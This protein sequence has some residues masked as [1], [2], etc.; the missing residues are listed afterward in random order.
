MTPCESKAVSL[1]PPTTRHLRDMTATCLRAPTWHTL[2]VEVEFNNDTRDS[3]ALTVDFN[4]Y[5]FYRFSSIFNYSL[6]LDQGT[7]SSIVYE[8]DPAPPIG[9]LLFLYKQI[10]SEDLRTMLA[11]SVMPAG[12]SRTFSGLSGWPRKIWMRDEVY[13]ILPLDQTLFS[14][15]STRIVVDPGPYPDAP[16]PLPAL[17]AAAA[18]GFSRR[19]RSRIR[20]SRSE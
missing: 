6:E 13:G 1:C 5:R 12:E 19:L 9:N 10:Y 8:S 3:Y 11:Y 18:V 14:S 20:A 16:G 15:Y 2:P 17:G 7:Y 4:R